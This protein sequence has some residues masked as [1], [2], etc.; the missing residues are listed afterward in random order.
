M[1]QNFKQNFFRTVISAYYTHIDGKSA[2][3]HY[4]VCSFNPLMPGGNKKV[5]LT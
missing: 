2:G 3:Q 4:L 5:T 1:L